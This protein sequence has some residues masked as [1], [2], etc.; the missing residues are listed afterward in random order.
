MK[1]FILKIVTV[2][3]LCITTSI[4]GNAIYLNKFDKEDYLLSNYA[5]VVLDLPI[6]YKIAKITNGQ[7]VEQIC[8][9]STEIGETGLQ[10]N[11]ILFL[12]PG[13]YTFHV[14]PKVRRG[15]AEW[16]TVRF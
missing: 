5:R 16:V 10:Q 2:L 8:N 3:C 15:K 4:Y 11:F 14:E 13:R 7:G 6:N 12:P 9:H 1:N